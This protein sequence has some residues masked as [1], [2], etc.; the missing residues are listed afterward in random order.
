MQ[1]WFKSVDRIKAL[2]LASREWVGTPFVANSRV[3]GPRG[4]VCC[5]MLAEQLYI[6]AGYPLPFRVPSGSMKWSDVQKESLIEQFFDKR[7]D[8]F[9]TLATCRS[10]LVAILPGDVIGFKI[11]G[12]VHHVGIAL[13]S[14][15]F[16]HSMRGLG[17][18]IFNLNDP[19]YESRIEK[20]WRP[21]P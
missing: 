17:T 21:K 4:G 8:I 1:T 6:E 3:K 16:I 13:L 18:K 2:E 19:T 15:R 5:H 12:C 11:G 7:T 10:P 9:H 20:I 14:G